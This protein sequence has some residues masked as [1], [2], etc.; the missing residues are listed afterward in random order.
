MSEPPGTPSGDELVSAPDPDV[1][2]LLADWEASEDNRPVQEMTI[3][4][5]RARYRDDIAVTSGRGDAFVSARD[6]AVPAGH[7]DIGVRLYSPGGGRSPGAVVVYL[8]GGGFVFGGLDT[9]DAVCR[10]LVGAGGFALVAVDYRLSP[11]HRYPDPLEDCVTAFSFV[12]EHVGELAGGTLPVA[13]AGDS[14]GGNLAAA[15]CLV[16][17]D[18]HEPLPTF[19]L[20]VYP[21]LDLTMSC[22]SARSFGPEYGLSSADLDW[23][24]DQYLEKAQRSEPAASPLL[25]DLAG[26]PPA[27]VVT[28]GY[29]PLRDEGRAYVGALRRAGVEATNGHYSSL[30]HGAFEFQA[31]VPA[32]RTL[33]EEAAGVLASRA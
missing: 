7:G 26:L 25:A 13:I 8:H 21:C 29:D 31:V 5:V 27:H 2:S 18:R 20:L 17:R 12:H 28:V 19:Q 11:E 6:L 24:Y 15:T 16:L 30:V 23:F 32:G 10:D 3:A 1:L 33:L 4:E 9:H 14:A 22:D